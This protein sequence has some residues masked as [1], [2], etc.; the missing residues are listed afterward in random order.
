MN[1]ARQQPGEATACTRFVMGSLF[2]AA[3]IALTACGGG[4]STETNPNISQNTGGGSSS[5]A[6]ATEDVQRFSLNFWSNAR[7]TDRCGQCHNATGTSPKFARSDDVNLAY[8]D[9]VRYANFSSAADSAFVTK[10][11]GG[12]NCWEG[13]NQVCADNITRWVQ[14]WAGTAA[15]L[16][17]K[18]IQLKAPPI[19][20]PGNTRNF[21]ADS[22]LFSG[23]HNLLKQ[24]CASCHADTAS[25]AIAPYFAQDDIAK[26]YEEV[27]TKI[28]LNNTTNSRLYVRLASEFHNCWSGTCAN[29]AAD[30]LAAINTMAGSIPTSSFDASLVAS[31]VLKLTDGIIASGGSRHEANL[32]ALYEFKTGTGGTAFDTSGVEPAIN[33]SL[34]GGTRWVGGYGIEFTNP[35]DRAQGT[36]A[37]SKKLYDFIQAA[38]EYS[39]E[40]WVIPNNVV[41]ED[42]TIMSYSAGDTVRNF[43]LSQNKYQAEY[44]NRASTTDGNGDTVLITRAQDEDLQASLQ[45]I[46]MTYDPIRGR[47]IYVNGVYTDDADPVSGGAL[48]NWNDSYVFVLGS[49]A[50]G[51]R[52]WKGQLRMVAVHNRALTQEQITR[53]FEA[54]VGEKYFL[55]FSVSH[56]TGIT[57]SYVYFE[58]SQFDSYSYLFTKPTFIILDANASP[59]NISIKGLRIGVNGQEA[60]IGQAFTRIDTSL[61]VANGYTPEAGQLLSSLGTI[62]PV[63]QGAANDEFFISFEVLGGN[64]KTYTEALPTAPTPVDLPAVSDIGLRTFE[65][66]NATLAA[67]TGVATTETNVANTYA[68]VRQQMPPTEDINAFL[69]ANQIG[70]AQLAGAY[71]GALVDSV[72]LRPDFFPSVNFAD[73]YTSFAGNTT[74]Q[75]NMINP[76]LTRLIGTT[77]LDTQPSL[78]DMRTE[79]RSLINTLAQCADNCGSN[80]THNLAKAACT[81]AYGN[82]A[83]LI[84]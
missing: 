39:V 15:T 50:G 69:S 68:R 19:K 54:G 43:T 60:A 81:A 59:A 20:E 71:C 5:I 8:A 21:P 48:N 72:T 80:R 76:I 70:I 26:A 28:D 38:G 74:L 78:N 64:S 52:P 4:A 63:D 49:E 33:L 42:A 58:V 53:N 22:A 18:T 66:I 67:L 13:V 35:G 30:M 9:A 11:G 27:K 34:A 6:P 12:H 51:T 44:R 79:L 61:S 55:L 25:P 41:Q 37:T 36:T 62:V 75:D 65:E 83:M 24:H 84:Q 47:R 3:S 56:L 46:T 16:S 10:V 57:D 45:H 29:D 40:G 73:A 1:K 17:S 77:D 31:K 7:R 2:I 32:I 23:V 82:A 14:G